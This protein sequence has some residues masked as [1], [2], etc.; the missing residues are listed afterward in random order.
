[1]AGFA[2]VSVCESS[3]R[4]RTERI[5]FS[6]REVAKK[7]LTATIVERFRLAPGEERLWDRNV[8]S[9]D[10]AS[11]APQRSFLSEASA[12]HRRNTVYVLVR[13]SLPPAR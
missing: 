10:H 6:R 3:P 4:V 12:R 2:V 7:G 5:S 13:T 9:L 8:L 11:G 1:V